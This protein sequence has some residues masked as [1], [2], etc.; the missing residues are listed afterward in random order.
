MNYELS[1]LFITTR[2]F[3]SYLAEVLQ[4][5][6]QLQLVFPVLSEGR[7][8]GMK[9]VGGVVYELTQQIKPPDVNSA[10]YPVSPFH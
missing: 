8:E 10:S 3:E 6:Q 4:G 9:P 1:E 5:K 2:Y 7:I